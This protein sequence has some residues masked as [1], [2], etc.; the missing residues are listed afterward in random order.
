MTSDTQRTQGYDRGISMERCWLAFQTGEYYQRCRRIML[1]AGM[2]EGDTE[3][4]LGNFWDEGFVTGSRIEKSETMTKEEEKAEKIRAGIAA[5]QLPPMSPEADGWWRIKVL[6]Q[7]C[8][9]RVE[10]ENGGLRIWWWRFGAPVTDVFVNPGSDSVYREE[11]GGRLYVEE[12]E[13]RKKVVS[14]PWYIVCGHC[15]VRYEEGQQTAYDLLCGDCAYC[16]D[17]C[18]DTEENFPVED[19]RAEVASGD[20]KLGYLAWREHWVESAEDNF[21]RRKGMYIKGEQAAPVKA[22]HRPE[23][24]VTEIAYAG[25]TILP[26]RSHATDVRNACQIELDWHGYAEKSDREMLEVGVEA[27]VTP[28]TPEFSWG[29]WK[30]W[31]SKAGKTFGSFHKGGFNTKEEADAAAALHNAAVLDKLVADLE[32]TLLP[33]PVMAVAV[34]GWDSGKDHQHSRVTLE[35]EYIDSRGEIETFQVTGVGPYQKGLESREAVRNAIA[36][37]VERL[38]SNEQAKK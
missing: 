33:R 19:W 6:G 3:M 26:Y 4:I 35:V 28:D 15:G 10:Y 31:G 22:E 24:D 20:T 18:A 13:P 23:N 1:D 7:W 9:A 2:G 34:V 37:V 21:D 27:F 11:W 38:R 8:P 5:G 36:Q 17:L 29:L 16:R 32:W 14:E 25:G 30:R 12:Q